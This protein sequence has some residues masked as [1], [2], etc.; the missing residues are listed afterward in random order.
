MSGF[1]GFF[2]GCFFLIGCSVAD[3]FFGSSAKKNGREILLS[4]SKKE[5]NP[6]ISMQKQVHWPVFWGLLKS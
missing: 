3:S 5:K 2:L 4:F 6:N 1:C